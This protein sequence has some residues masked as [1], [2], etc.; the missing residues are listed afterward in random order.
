MNRNAVPRLRHFSRAKLPAR[1]VDEG[2]LSESR[3]RPQVLTFVCLHPFSHGEQVYDGAPFAHWPFEQACSWH[4]AQARASS[5]GDQFFKLSYR[6]SSELLGRGSKT[7]QECLEGKAHVK[8]A[9]CVRLGLRP[10]FQR[11]KQWTWLRDATKRH[12]LAAPCDPSPGLWLY[13]TNVNGLHKATSCVGA[14]TASAK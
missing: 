6:M 1:R 11:G 2:S 9:S 5:E 4:R 10:R 3:L 7:A 12:S 14:I 13:V 8:S